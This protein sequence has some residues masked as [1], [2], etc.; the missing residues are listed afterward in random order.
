MIPNSLALVALLGVLLNV[1]GTVAGIVNVARAVGDYQA[2]WRT[3]FRDSMLLIC[4]MRVWYQSLR[5]LTNVLLGFQGLLLIA[6]VT[7]EV[8]SAEPVVWFWL[9]VSCLLGGTTLQRLNDQRKLIKFLE[10]EWKEV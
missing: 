7:D 9:A 8:H 5:L 4:R 10:K 2:I 6:L 3:D 1:V